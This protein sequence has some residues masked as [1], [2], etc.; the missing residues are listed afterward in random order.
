MVQVFVRDH[1][2]ART[3]T[4]TTDVMGIVREMYVLEV[5]PSYKVQEDSTI[6]TVQ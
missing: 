5:D 6:R 1:R 2:A 3:Q 4:T